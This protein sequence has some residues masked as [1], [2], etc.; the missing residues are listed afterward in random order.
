VKYARRQ[1]RPAHDS[2]MPK[3]PD[4]SKKNILLLDAEVKIEYNDSNAITFFLLIIIYFNVS[5]NDGEISKIHEAVIPK[6]RIQIN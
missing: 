5:F 3:K 2:I 6:K 4:Y 1:K